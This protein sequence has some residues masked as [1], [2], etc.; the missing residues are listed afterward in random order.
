MEIRGIKAGSPAEPVIMGILNVTPDSFSDAGAY[1]NAPEKAAQ[2]ALK[3]KSEGASII[4]I[5]GESSKP[6]S[7]P[8]GVA[9]ELER[10]IPVIR[11]IRKL[12][13]ELL[14]SIDTYKS[15]TASAAISEG[16]DIVND[17]YAGRFDGKIMETA[18][19]TKTAYIM[20]HMNG[21]PETM[22]DS[23]VY[24]KLGAVHDIKEFFSGRIEAAIAA[25]IDKN[26]LILDPGIG[27]GKTYEDN[28]E[29][30]KRLEE[31]GSFGLPLLA[32][33]SRKSMIGTI[34]GGAPAG[35][36]IFGTAAAVAAAVCA[37]VSIVRVHDVREMTQVVKTAAALRPCGGKKGAA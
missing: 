3:M 34:L 16:A 30:M 36:R 21:T 15:E 4:D 24:S 18:A 1:Y 13:R 5:G 25:G 14:I 28:I 32:G 26:M 20:M 35:E 2:A 7:K 19:R 27:F 9:E 22:Q 6:G 29:I 31:F 12:D 37:G 11:Q 33:V 17:I 10:V 8:L 23:P